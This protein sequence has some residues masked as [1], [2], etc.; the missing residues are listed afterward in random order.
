MSNHNDKN[1][2][3]SKQD[4]NLWDK[5]AKTVKGKKPEPKIK[6]LLETK[7]N[8]NKIAKKIKPKPPPKPTPK[9]KPPPIPP[10]IIGNIGG[11]DASTF[12]KLSRGNLP[13]ESRIDLHALTRQ[14]AW[15]EVSIWIPDCY[16]H[17]KRSLLLVTGKGTGVL[18]SALPIFLNHVSLRPYVLCCIQAAPKDGGSG[19]FYIYLKH[20]S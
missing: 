1:V 2:F 6:S 20:S 14:Q 8:K 12:R 17:K 13:I 16:Y 19:A 3:T 11:I 9:P 4:Q 5:F 10:L 18:Q 7:P 15:K